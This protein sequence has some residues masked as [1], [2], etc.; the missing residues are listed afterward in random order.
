MRN[1][2][3]RK[4]KKKTAQEIFDA[5]KMKSWASPL[6]ITKIKQCVPVNREEKKVC[7]KDINYWS[8][9]YLEGNLFYSLRW[10]IIVK[11]ILSNSILKNQVK[12]IWPFFRSLF[13]TKKKSKN[14]FLC[15]VFLI[16][17][18]D[19]RSKIFCRCL[20]FMTNA[21]FC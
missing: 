1:I 18:I 15:A 17:F 6:K 3:H 20:W 11:F 4:D 7:P 9:N 10:Y 12:K 16:Q 13:F 2:D 19:F 14:V 8:Q 21:L 5:T